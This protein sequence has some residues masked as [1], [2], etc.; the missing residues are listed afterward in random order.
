MVV[1]GAAKVRLYGNEFILNDGEKIDIP[2]GAGHR[3]ENT[4]SERLIFIEIQRG[5]YLGEGDIARLQ[6]DYGWAR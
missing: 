5:D 1:A 3:I 6:D 2:I 4:A